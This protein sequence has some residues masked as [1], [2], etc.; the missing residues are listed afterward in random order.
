VR[1]SGLKP[2]ENVAFH[3]V[4][5]GHV[6]GVG[7]RFFVL[8]RAEALNISG[9]VRNTYNDEV[10]VHAEGPREAL[11]LFENELRKGPPS[12]YVTDIQLKW[13]EPTGKVIGFHIVSTY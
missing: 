11:I 12:A 5:E 4:I 8:N 10:E 3:A 7:F 6:Q 9:W 13:I 1:G 2:E